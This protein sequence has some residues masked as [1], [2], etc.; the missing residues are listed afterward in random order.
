[1][2]RYTQMGSSRGH[3]LVLAI[4]R[5]GIIA[6]LYAAM[7]YLLQPVSFGMWQFRLSEA[8]TVL[9]FFMPEAVWGLFIGC[10]VANLFSWNSALLLD[11]IVGSLA[12]LAAAYVTSKIR[13]R[14]LAPLPPVLFNAVFVGLV[15]AV[16]Q[17]AG[18]NGAA[19][20]AAAWG[21]NALSVGVC[22]FAV[23]Y[24]IGLPL[25][26]LLGR[27]LFRGRGDEKRG[28]ATEKRKE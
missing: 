28:A 16:S 15:L 13:S 7:T 6:A 10:I 11:V 18:A 12:T 26:F 14:Y 22:E 24:A 9:P 27:T 23:C 2:E 5:A 21:I 20:F 4:T 25:I 3:A 19:A 8:L 17:A 1:M